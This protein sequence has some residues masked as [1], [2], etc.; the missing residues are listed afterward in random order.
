MRDLQVSG[1]PADKMQEMRDRQP[2]R[3][4]AIRLVI[5]EYTSKDE[6]AIADCNVSAWCETK[7]KEWQKNPDREIEVKIATQ[8]MW[9]QLSLAVKKG[10]ITDMAIKIDDVVY[11]ITL[12]NGK[13][14]G[15][16]LPKETSA[17]CVYEELLY[18]LL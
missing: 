14:I 5:A 17:L 9:A 16:H 4:N 15:S 13:S 10:F 6:D 2:K 3:D 18:Q 11:F 7:L 12:P 8:V 1:I